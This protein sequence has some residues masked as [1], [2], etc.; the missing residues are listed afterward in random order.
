L[1][2]ILFDFAADGLLGDLLDALD[3]EGVF[4]LQRP[5]VLVEL[6]D[7]FVLALPTAASGFTVLGP[8]APRVGCGMI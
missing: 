6:V 7:A 1:Q 8:P 5:Y 2:L 3:E 4:L